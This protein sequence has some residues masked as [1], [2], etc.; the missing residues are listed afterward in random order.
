MIQ[1]KGASVSFN[2]T[3]FCIESTNVIESG[4]IN[5]NVFKASLYIFIICLIH[6]CGL[7][8][9]HHLNNGTSFQVYSVIKTFSSPYVKRAL[10]HISCL[11]MIVM[12]CSTHCIHVG[13]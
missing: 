5:I 1:S 7:I 2:D 11:L 8:S 10:K 3:S 13:Y 12:E 4:K 6:T 9:T